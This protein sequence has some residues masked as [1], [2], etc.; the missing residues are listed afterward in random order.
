MNEQI[1]IDFFIQLTPEQ[2]EYIADCWIDFLTQD[3]GLKPCEGIIT[4][5]AEKVA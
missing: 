5:T 1:I 4:F 3:L 2:R